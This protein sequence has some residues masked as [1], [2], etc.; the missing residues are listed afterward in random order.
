M[1]DKLALVLSGGS[2]RAAAQVGVLQAVEEYNLRPQVVVGTSGGSIVAALYA[3]GLSASELRQLFLEYS[4]A[5][6]KVVDLNW[7]GAVLALVTWDYRRLAGAVRGKS[8]EEIIAQSLP[9]QRFQDLTKC[10]LLI[11]AVNLNNGQPTVFCAYKALGL[12]PDVDGEYEGYLLRDDLTI[13][14]AVRASI[15]IPGVFVP[16]AFAQDEDCYV[17]G[18]LRDGYPLNIA[19]RLGQAQRVLGVNLGYAGMRR[20]T[21]LADGPLE[22]LNQ[23]LDIMIWAQFKD[24][25][26]DR[27][28][29]NTRLITINPLIYNIGTF[30]VEYIPEMI[31]RG[32]EVAARLFRE[33]GLTP[34]AADNQERLFRMVR[35]P[36]SFPE[37]NSPY[38][39]Y[40]LENQIKKR[41]EEPAAERS[42]LRHLRSLVRRKALG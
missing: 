11:P 1:S 32:Y 35:A 2:V 14:Q 5:K 23:S 36:L 20:D 19:V 12:Q 28:L 38:F 24:R 39:N 37:K 6:G 42:V 15:S 8:L 7:P 25:L 29:V 9:I 41:K 30:E 10:Q 33:R 16:A 3:A 18:G 34:G 22:I 21:I 40:L 13:S 17:D 4:R 31:A 27:A 26:Q